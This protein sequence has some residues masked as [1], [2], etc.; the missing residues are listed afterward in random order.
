MS[1]TKG[2]VTTAGSASSQRPGLRPEPAMTWENVPVYH[3]ATAFRIDRT[4]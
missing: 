3:H 1:N 2:T 4:T